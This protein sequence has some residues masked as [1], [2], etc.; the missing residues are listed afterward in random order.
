[1]RVLT[2]LYL[3]SHGGN[4]AWEYRRSHRHVRMGNGKAITFV[5]CHY[6]TTVGVLVCGPSIS[7]RQETIRNM[8]CGISGRDTPEYQNARSLLQQ[9][10][11]EVLL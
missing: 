2:A 8:A 6:L 11:E 4:V 7:K 9:G 10:S 1:M 5:G 3:A